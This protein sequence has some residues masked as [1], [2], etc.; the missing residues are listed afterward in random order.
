MVYT[1]KSLSKPF[2][3]TDIVKN[4]VP[5]VVPLSPDPGAPRHK[6]YIAD[7]VVR[8]LL[9]TALQLPRSL[10]ILGSVSLQGFQQAET[11]AC[12][13]QEGVEESLY[14]WALVSQSK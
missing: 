3:D 12:C 9:L 11:D 1:V 2:P 4:K 6:V 13:S 10:P 8:V 7:K 14:N 5:D